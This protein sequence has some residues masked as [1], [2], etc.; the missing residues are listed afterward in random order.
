MRIAIHGGAN[1][2]L[3]SLL[4]NLVTFAEV[5]GTPHSTLETRIEET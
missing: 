3:E 1:K 4:V 5:Y 2:S